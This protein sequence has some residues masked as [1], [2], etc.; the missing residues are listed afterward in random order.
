MRARRVSA[1]VVVVLGWSATAFA[2]SEPPAGA[3]SC[4]GCHS[5]NTGVQ[6]PVPPLAGKNAAEIVA[7][8]QAFR[9]GQRP[10]TV[11]G[12]VAKGFSEAEVQ[13]IAAWYAQQH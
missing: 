1:A 5:P 11:M 10:A 7:Q 12:R 3:A 6:S 9:T 4:S 2:A 8:M 13:A